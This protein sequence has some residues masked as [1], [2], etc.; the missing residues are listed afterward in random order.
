M[1]PSIDLL[2]NYSTLL[3]NCDTCQTIETFIHMLHENP[4]MRSELLDSLRVAKETA[5]VQLDPNLYQALEW[6]LTEK[7]YV[8]YLIT[9]AMWIPQPDPES[10]WEQPTERDEHQE[11]YDRL[12]HFHY[13]IDQ[14]HLK[15]NQ[16]F[17]EWLVTYSIAWGSFLDTPASFNKHILNK[18]IELTP[19]Y[20]VQ[21][22]MITVYGIPRSN[23]PSGWLTFNQFFARE[24]NPGLRPIDAARDNHTVC[25]PADC[26]YRAMYDINTDSE[27]QA[28][29]IKKTHEYASIPTLLMG[30]APP[31]PFANAF[32]GGKFVHYFLGPYSYHRFH[33]P[34]SGT[35]IAC[36]PIQG[37]TVLDVKITFGQFYAPDN[38]EDGYEFRQARGVIVFD[39][40]GSPD[41]DVGLVAVIPIGMTHVSS[42]NMT[43]QTGSYLMKGQEFGYFM[44]GGSD[45]IVL[46]QK[47][48]ASM[49]SEETNYR[50]YGTAIATLN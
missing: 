44:F 48:K 40:S 23:N 29:R 41:G 6:P 25:C 14:S 17:N 18:F 4:G 21:N 13:L 34:V 28:I 7:G 37:L 47:G 1:R 15:D 19:N 35:V 38:A 36:Y 16:Q 43:A 42:V 46:F 31:A 3:G 45:I 49:I 9:F 20:E 5:S 22:S 11:V 33:A 50:H 30:T 32:A 10:Y 8:N 27:I 26:T 12:C 39:T 2:S 24:L